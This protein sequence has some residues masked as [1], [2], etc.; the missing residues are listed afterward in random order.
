[1]AAGAVVLPKHLL[2]GLAAVPRAEHAALG[3]GAVGMAQ[4][5]DVDDGRGCAD[6]PARGPICCESASPERLHVRPPS[7][8]LYMPSPW[9]MSERMSASP[10]PA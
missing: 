6:R 1:M 10:E 4:R 7:A 5:R 3:V 2:P 9:A 8:D